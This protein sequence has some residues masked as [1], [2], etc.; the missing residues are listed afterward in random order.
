MSWTGWLAVFDRILY[1]RYTV[2][3]ELEV[4]GGVVKINRWTFCIAKAAPFSWRHR[5]LTLTGPQIH[6]WLWFNWTDWTDGT[7]KPL[8]WQE[9]VRDEHG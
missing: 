8:S 6:H 3:L 4:A 5:I 1:G 7:P 2:K 9:E